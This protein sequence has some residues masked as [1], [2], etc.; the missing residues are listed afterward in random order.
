MSLLPEDWI[1]ACLLVHNIIGE[2]FH[3]LFIVSHAKITMLP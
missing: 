2:N 1:F 3:S